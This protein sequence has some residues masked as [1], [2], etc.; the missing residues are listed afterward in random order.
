MSR[1]S[2]SVHL[3]LVPSH[4]EASEAVAES[5]ERALHITPMLRTGGALRSR[6]PN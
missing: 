5:A 4:V 6:S 2:S 1:R 3:A